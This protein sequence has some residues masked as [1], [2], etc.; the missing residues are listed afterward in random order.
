M[1][2]DLK[3]SSFWSYVFRCVFIWHLDHQMISAMTNRLSA[4][5]KPSPC[6]KERYTITVFHVRHR[7]ILLTK[8]QN[9]ALFSGLNTFSLQNPVEITIMYRQTES[10][11]LA[12][13][14][15]PRQYC[16]SK[17]GQ[18]QHVLLARLLV[19]SS[20]LLIAVH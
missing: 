6:R 13:V 18:S 3:K 11:V 9:Q 7:V 4:G 16:R 20:F 8:P 12:F 5:V 2:H 17:I 1:F 19:K 15:A 14:K 10:F